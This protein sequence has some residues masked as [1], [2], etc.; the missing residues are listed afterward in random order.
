MDTKITFKVFYAGVI[1]ATII[2]VIIIS[3]KI[4]TVNNKIYY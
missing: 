3:I 2:I 1:T 4:L